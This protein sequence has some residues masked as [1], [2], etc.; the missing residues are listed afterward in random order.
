MLFAC[1]QAARGA[2][3]PKVRLRASVGIDL[4]TVEGV[5]YL[6]EGSP[7]SLVDVQALLPVPQ[8]DAD[9][10]RT[11]PGKPE[12]GWM[13]IERQSPGEYLFHSLMPRRFGAVGKAPRRG[14]YA[15]GFW[16]PQPVVDDRLVAIDWDVEIDV[17]D[18]YTVILNGLIGESKLSWQG[19][20]STLSLA[21]LPEAHIEP[22]E[23]DGR[24]AFWVRTSPPGERRREKLLACLSQLSSAPSTSPI[25]I[26]ETPLRRRLYRA[27]EHQLYLSDR[28]L[29]VSGSLWTHHGPVVARGV[30]ESG[31]PIEEPWERS[32]AA[33]AL[34]DSIDTVESVEE[35]LAVVSWI[36]EV[37]AL[38][39]DGR[40]PFYSDIFDE[41]WP[42][43]RVEDSMTQVLRPEITGRAMAR[44]L[45]ALYGTDRV[46]QM[47]WDLVRG[48]SLENSAVRAGIPAAEL[49]HRAVPGHGQDY[50]V[51]ALSSG[52]EWTVTVSRDAPPDAPSE[53]VIIEFDESKRIWRTQ[54]GPDQWIETLPDRPTQIRVDPPG[55]VRQSE[56]GNDAWPRASST[57]LAFF[58]SHLSLTQGILVAAADIVYRPQVHGR[59]AWRLS[60]GTD[61]EDLISASLTRY[62]FKGSLRDRR[63]R[64]LRI[65]FGG[66]AGLLDPQ[67]RP[68]HDRTVALGAHAGIAWDTRDDYHFPLHGHRLSLS[69]SGG[70]VPGEDSWGSIQLR[71]VYIL[72]ARGRV[73]SATRVRGGLASGGVEHR[74]L[75]LGG[76]GGLWSL[77]PGAQV[78]DQMLVGS[79]E[80]RIQAIRGASIPLPALWLADVNLSVGVEA[81]VLRAPCLTEVC[82]W[83]GIGATAGISFVGDILGVR[84]SLLGVWGA[85]PV[86]GSPRETF[87]DRQPQI[88]IRFTQPF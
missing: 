66:G 32:L 33:T 15:N 71:G 22:I 5:L 55:L 84:P 59:H 76:V 41:T 69:G 26:I 9:L 87:A 46:E 21:V 4:Q 2:E 38:L 18:G 50:S 17:P 61:E 8:Q 40:L 63:T 64:P 44:R 23:S 68:L 74:L 54:A 86:S 39:H 45:Q 60:A 47:A 16:F 36:P 24:A 88:I 35:R 29:R 1:S 37:E 30:L 70:L 27:G 75:S 31:L 67:Y 49:A 82:A 42:G 3:V 48:Q 77:P 62:T 14:L 51:E 56:P 6:E 25:T 65:W 7:L 12:Q 34:A 83:Q 20:A 78:G 10:R 13:H 72:S 80:V 11:F 79:T 81:G 19:R 43:D 28:A 52:D 73:V 85:V 58:P 57:T 53:V